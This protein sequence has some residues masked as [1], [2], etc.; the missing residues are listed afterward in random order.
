M[1]KSSSQLQSA[2]KPSVIVFG[3]DGTG[4]SKAGRFSERHAAAATNAAKSLKLSICS[5]AKPGIEGLLKNIP[6]GRL[7]AQGKAFIPYVKRELF[8]QIQAAASTTALAAK[9][10]AGPT[11]TA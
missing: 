7:H 3:L 2:I 8:D 11:I 4:K 1:T 10:K 6:V 5:T 9:S